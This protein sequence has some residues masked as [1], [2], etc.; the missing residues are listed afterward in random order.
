MIVSFTK[1]SFAMVLL[2][3][4]SKHQ[5]KKDLPEEWGGHPIGGKLTNLEKLSEQVQTIT[6]FSFGV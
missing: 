4:E 2:S 3:D 6:M 1:K 5:T